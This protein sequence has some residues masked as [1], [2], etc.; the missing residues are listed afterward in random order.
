MSIQLL[1]LLLLNFTIIKTLKIYKN[2]LPL[3]AKPQTIGLHYIKH[4][5]QNFNPTHSI[6]FCIR[7]NYKRL[8]RNSQ[9]FHIP[10]AIQTNRSTT[11]RYD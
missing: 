3:T 1:L 2:T 7:F 5:N 11:N 6:T 8:G 10:A 4:D 9:I